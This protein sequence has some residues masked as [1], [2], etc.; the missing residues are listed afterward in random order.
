M[1]L[2]AIRRMDDGTLSA[3]QEERL[4]ETLMRAEAAIQDLAAKFGLTP[5]DLSLSLGPLGRTV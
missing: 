1:E 5:D 4:G 3:H 2:Q